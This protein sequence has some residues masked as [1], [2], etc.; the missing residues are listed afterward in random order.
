LASSIGSAAGLYGRLAPD[1]PSA[2]LGQFSEPTLQSRYQAQQNRWQR[3]DV[4]RRAILT[5]VRG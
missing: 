2:V 4:N 3:S 5:P 1:E